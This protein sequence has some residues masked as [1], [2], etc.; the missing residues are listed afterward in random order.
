[1]TVKNQNERAELQKAIGYT[2]KD[3]GLLERALIHSSYSN[4]MGLKNHHMYCNERLEFLGDSVLS[5]IVS[6]HLF[7]GGEC[8]ADTGIIGDLAILVEGHIE[9]HAND[10]ALAFEIVSFDFCH[11]CKVIKFSIFRLDIIGAKLRFFSEYT[12]I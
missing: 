6:E 3:E 1:M 5:I 4:E 9:I 10:R 12:Y 2:F 11:S 8:T 7:E